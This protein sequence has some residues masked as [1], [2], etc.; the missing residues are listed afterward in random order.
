MAVF[1]PAY[2]YPA[3][4]FSH[5]T[6]KAECGSVPIHRTDWLNGE[7]G[8]VALLCDIALDGLL[9]TGRLPADQPD[10]G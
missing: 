2:F 5:P 4:L 9:V 8:R 3:L 10:A 6:V 7:I 1:E